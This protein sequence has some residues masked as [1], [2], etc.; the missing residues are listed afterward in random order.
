MIARLLDGFIAIIIGVMLLKPITKII[1]Q[2][3]NNMT[4][5][6]LAASMILGLIPIFFAITILGIALAT[7]WGALRSAGLSEDEE[8][9]EEEKPKLKRKGKQTYLDYVKERK[10]IERLMNSD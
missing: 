8:I 9:E 10:E 7:A 3:Q 2:V 1:L 5:D 6:S 4:S